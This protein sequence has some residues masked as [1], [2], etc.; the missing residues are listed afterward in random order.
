MRFLLNAASSFAN[1]EPRITN[2]YLLRAAEGTMPMAQ[3]IVKTM[4]ACWMC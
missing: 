4:K 2:H 1:H 3:R